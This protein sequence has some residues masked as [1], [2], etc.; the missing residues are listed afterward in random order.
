MGFRAGAC[1][2]DITPDT[3]QF[4][5]GYPHV[6]RY[7]TGV[8]DPLS[9][10][11]LVLERDGAYAAFVTC[12]VIF[13]DRTLV[14]SARDRIAE[15]TDIPAEHVFISA[16]HTHSGPITVDHVSNEGDP[17]VPKADPAYRKKLES[18]MVEAVRSAFS[19]RIPARGGLASA[20]AAGVGTNRRDPD[21]PADPEVP[22]L[23]VTSTEGE[24]IACM[25]VCSMH[26]TVLHEDSTL[27]TADFPGQARAYVKRE[28]IG[29]GTP[30][31]YHTGPAGNQSPRHVTRENTFAEA[32]RLGGILGASV[33]DALE[34]IELT[35]DLDVEVRSAYVDLP[36]RR[37][38]SV[39]EA[40]QALDRAVSTLERLRGSDASRQEVRTAEV[41]WFGAEETLTLARAAAS[42]RTEE[43]ARE[44]LPAQVMGVRLGPWWFIGLPGEL[45]VEYSLA[46]KERC[47]G[48][49]VVSLANGELQGY[50]VTAEA[51]AEGG[52]EASNALF[53]HTAGDILVKAA[54][55]LLGCR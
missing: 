12:D 33:V 17:V 10:T 54:L 5:F 14:S 34:A 26:P 52:Y 35:D 9:C 28:A 48:T 21:G 13:V 45:F 53:E 38:R 24:P 8:H 6:E 39:S 11:A 19:R 42:G 18:A 29:E 23:Y 55:D 1:V 44:R 25:V 30:F 40:E 3:S 41:D 50:I 32:E 36:T 49:Y 4:L 20:S 22:V 47:P 16:T 2:R 46:I 7:S 51:A 31:L 15:S 43:A 37:F 27:V